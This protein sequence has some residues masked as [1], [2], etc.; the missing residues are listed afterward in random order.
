ML[1]PCMALAVLCVRMIGQEREL[2]EKRRTDQKQRLLD[3]VRQQLLSRLE[4]I[5]RDEL[6]SDHPVNPEVIFLARI[7]DR[8]IV[9]PWESERASGTLRKLLAQ[10]PFERIVREGEREEYTDRQP[11]LAAE[12]YLRALGAARHPAQS[13]YARLLAARALDKAGRPGEALGH[14]RILLRLPFEFRDEEGVPLRLYAAERLSQSAQDRAAVFEALRPVVAAWP[15]LPP[16]A[17]YV[18]LNAADKLGAGDLHQAVAA[19]I[20]HIEQ[21]QALQNDF[22]RLDL[23]HSKSSAPVWIRYGEEPWL[24]SVAGAPGGPAVLTAVR[25]EA[26]FNSVEAL[27][28]KGRDLRFLGPRESGGELLG[29]NFPGLRVALQVRED[30]AFLRRAAQQRQFLYAA[31]A[32]VLGVTM[33]GAY[34]LWSDLRRELRLAEVRAQFVSSVSHELK[35]PLT[36]IRM[37]AET[38]QM[39]R[40]RDPHT[41]SEYLDTIVNECERLSRLVDGVLL[42]SKIEQGKKVYNFRLACLASAVEA[43]ARALQYPLAQRGFRLEI[44]IEEDLPAVRADQ[45]ALEQA[46]LNLLTNAMKYSG[47]CRQIELSIHKDNGCAVIQV[48]D[49]GVGIALEEHARIFEKFYRAPS[50]ENE[51]I[52][53]TGLGLALVA[54]IAKAHGGA[55]HVSSVPGE[56][57]TFAI[58]LPL[59]NEAAA[60]A[61]TGS[62]I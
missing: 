35:T 30:A 56:G 49:H 52:P 50:R 23:L 54:Q 28:Q 48:T 20:R 58:R 37:F 3:Q 55:V 61:A 27:W 44:H 25:A 14:F 22:P 9:L 6:N 38:L 32:L 7:E 40:S 16:P 2:A 12:T 4:A 51:L 15:S 39:G 42:F 34:I 45:D 5:K 24:V 19:Q 60:Q 29:D 17:C 21:A 13:G 59:G 43:A 1:V 41:Q 31:L 33:F 18:L 57:S 11:A 47:D 62:R 53:G 8:K 10:Q 26:L 46:I 36:A